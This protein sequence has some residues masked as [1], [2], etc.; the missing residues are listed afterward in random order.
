MVA[1]G[2][3]ILALMVV[4]NTVTDLVLGAIMVGMIYAMTILDQP[5]Q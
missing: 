2:I 1:A 4:A 3:G 5:K